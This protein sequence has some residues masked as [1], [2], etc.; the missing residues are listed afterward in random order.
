MQDT[1][2]I[3]EPEYLLRTHT[4][5]VE[6]RCMTQEEPP[7]RIVSP[8]KTYRNESTNASNN[9]IFYMY[10][11]L[12]VD[13]GMHMGHLRATLE[14]FAKFL[15]GNTIPTRFRCK[16]YPQVEP[17]VGLDIQC[18]LCHGDGCAVCKYRGWM[19]MLGAGMVHPNALKLCGIDPEKWSG[20][21]FGVGL[22]RVVMMKYGIT[23]IRTLYNGELVWK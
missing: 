13:R 10:E 23:D 5:S 22:D 17:G 9:A 1:L 12:V 19:E 20:Y 15:F 6:T 16:Y 7:I 18:Q 14:N 8:G 4:S 11:G 2:Y 3:E 21:A